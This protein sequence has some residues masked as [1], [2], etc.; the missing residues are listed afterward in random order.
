LLEK[1]LA[2]VNNGDEKDM[3]SHSGHIIAVANQKGGVGKTTTVVNLAQGLALLDQ[4]ILALDFDPQ[5]NL[6]QGLGVKLESIQMSVVDLIRKRELPE[7][8]AIYKG[9]QIDIIP[10]TP[11]L[12]QVEREMVGLTNSEL[13]LAHRL[14]KLRHQYS[15]ILIDTA[16]TFGPLM[17]SALNA[18]DSIIVPVD[19]N[20]YAL[21]GIKSLLGEIDEIKAGTNPNVEI[22]GYLLT[23]FDSTRITGEVY[24][25]L[26]ESFGNKVF[27][28]KVRRSVK[29]REAPA[30]GR[31]IF[32]HAPGSSGSEDYL[33]LSREVLARLSPKTAA[34]VETSAH[35]LNLIQGGGVK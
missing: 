4:S 25:G 35:H 19:S 15:V 11:A 2:A 13:R 32:H 14:R 27:E 21:Q 17:N 5:A 8:A 1:S 29:L 33:K 22:L 28:T 6:T 7:H 9:S 23:L 10:A 31:T 24:E 26:I 16:P 3:N 12:S 30:L 34:S 20:L 18:A